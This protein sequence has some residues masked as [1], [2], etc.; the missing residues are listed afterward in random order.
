MLPVLFTEL[1]ECIVQ[2]VS[3]FSNVQ[4]VQLARITLSLSSVI[5]LSIA[6]VVLLECPEYCIV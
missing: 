4:N 3:S 5:L 2:H 6:S 1:M